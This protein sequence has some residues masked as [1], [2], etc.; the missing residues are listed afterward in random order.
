MQ[1]VIA[2]NLNGN[3]YQIDESGYRRAG[4]PISMAPSGS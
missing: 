4:S 2:I 3:A 1:K